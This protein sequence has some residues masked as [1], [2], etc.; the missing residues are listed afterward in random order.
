MGNT[1]ILPTEGEEGNVKDVSSGQVLGLL[2]DA[3]VTGTEVV[4][5]AT[6]LSFSGENQ[7]E[8]RPR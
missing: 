8:F 2:D 5:E 4:L 6:D 1:W 7:I 3:T